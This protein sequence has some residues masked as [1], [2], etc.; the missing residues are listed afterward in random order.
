MADKVNATAPDD[1][2]EILT[3]MSLA[4][5]RA[6]PGKCKEMNDGEGGD[7]PCVRIYGTARGIKQTVGKNGDA[8]YALTGAFRGINIANGKSYVSAILYLPGG[9][10][11]LILG[12]LDDALA[13]SEDTPADPNAS[14]QFA[15]D[16][17]SFPAP[18]PI[19]YSYKARDLAPTSRVDPLAEMTAMLEAKPLPALLLT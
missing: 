3:K 18:N 6:F 1:A 11:E 9:V 10:Q 13:G 4:T 19:G 2:N 12:P 16:I 7:Y 14:I 8:T 15:F 17:I 5:L